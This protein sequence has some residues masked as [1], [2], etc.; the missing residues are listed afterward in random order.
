VTPLRPHMI[1]ALQLSGNGAR[2]QEASVRAVRLLA[3]CSHTSPD[4]LSAQALQPSFLPRQNVDGLAPAALRSC[5]SGMRC[6]SQP[7]LQR[8]WPTL[9][10]LRAH[11]A[12]RL[13]AVRSGEA[14][15]RLLKAATPLHNH[16][17]C[18]PV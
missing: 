3:Q 7:V 15:R 11:T 1:A 17:S 5:Y 13:P 12:H 9:S 10:R 18:T 6:C 8:A 2:T 16:V 4:R 14:V